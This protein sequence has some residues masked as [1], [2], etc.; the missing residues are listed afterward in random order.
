MLN[1]FG[2]FQVI[3]IACFNEIVKCLV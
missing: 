2:A 1:R 3:L